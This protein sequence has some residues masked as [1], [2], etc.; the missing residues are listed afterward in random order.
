MLFVGVICTFQHIHHPFTL[1]KLIGNR[2]P[3]DHAQPIR[4][5]LHL[6]RILLEHTCDMNINLDK[7]GIFLAIWFYHIPIKSLHE[8]GLECWCA[9]LQLLGDNG[10]GA[11]HSGLFFDSLFG[12]VAA[13]GFSFAGMLSMASLFPFLSSSTSSSLASTSSSLLSMSS[14]SLLLM[15]CLRANSLQAQIRLENMQEKEKTLQDS[16][17]CPTH[18]PL[19]SSA[20]QKV[21]ATL[22]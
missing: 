3:P 6:V 10:G 17:L 15:P 22:L 18:V 20:S 12:G 13:A 4:A 14:S 19:R 2:T 1:K 21:F 9:D 7:V 5:Q 8:E 16:P 11:L